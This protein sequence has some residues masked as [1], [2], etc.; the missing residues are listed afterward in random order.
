MGELKNVRHER[1]CL[2]YA[3]SGNAV[4]SYKRAG[5]KSSTYSAAGTNSARLLKNDQVRARLAELREE[6]RSAAI[7]DV[8]EIQEFLTSVVRGDDLDEK[9]TTDELGNINRTEVRN[10]NNQIKAAEL[11]AKMQ[12]AYDGGAKVSVIVP[13]IGG[14][15]ELSD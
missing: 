13:V 11:L 6:M 3:K 15:S 10:Q 1:F 2:E 8:A 5:Y 14:E 12:G 4:E 7:A 9:L